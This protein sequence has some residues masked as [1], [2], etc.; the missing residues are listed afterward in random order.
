MDEADGAV[1]F[2]NTVCDVTVARLVTMHLSMYL[3]EKLLPLSF[4]VTLPFIVATT[5]ILC[6]LLST[7]DCFSLYCSSILANIRTLVGVSPALKNFI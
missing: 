5:E 3:V 6:D 2:A 7:T 4:A 1:V